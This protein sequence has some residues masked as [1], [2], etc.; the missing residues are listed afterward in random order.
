MAAT[1]DFHIRFEGEFYNEYRV[2]FERLVYD[3]NQITSYDLIT[4]ISSGVDFNAAL[5]DL[6]NFDDSV[7]YSV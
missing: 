5:I 1:I 7:V 6:D 4:E 3:P 2:H